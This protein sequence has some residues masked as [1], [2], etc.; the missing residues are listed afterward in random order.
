MMFVKAKSV[1]ALEQMG[2]DKF[3]PRFLRQDLLIILQLQS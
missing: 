1:S 2:D 3:L